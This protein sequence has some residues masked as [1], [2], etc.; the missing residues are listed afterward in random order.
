MTADREEKWTTPKSTAPTNLDTYESQQEQKT[1]CEWAMYL[2]FSL[3]AGYLIPIAG[4]VAPLI[5]WQVKKDELPELD[6]HGKIVTNWLI[7]SLIYGVIS[8]F[9]IFMIVGIPL[10]AVLGILNVVFPI[11]GGL[12]A[13]QGKCWKYPL[14]IQFIS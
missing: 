6:A 12:K 11:I 8:F 2:H 13:N 9:L 4:F 5:I 7:S 3:L 14:S 10:L 1:T